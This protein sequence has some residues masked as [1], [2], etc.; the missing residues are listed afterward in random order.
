MYLESINLIFVEINS[1]ARLVFPETIFKL[2]NN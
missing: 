2:V 1:F